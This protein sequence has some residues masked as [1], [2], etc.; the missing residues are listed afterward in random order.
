MKLLHQE[1]NDIRLFI[2][3]KL[4][5]PRHLHNALEVAFMTKGHSTAICG[6]QRIDLQAGDV[7]VAFPNQ[8]HGYENTVDVGGYVM[9]VPV[10]PYLASFHSI[11]EQKVPVSPLLKKG[12]WEH[13]GIFSLLDMAFPEWLTAPKTVRQGYS[14]LIVGKLM[15]LL[16]LKDAPSGCADALQALLLFINN[17]YTE[18]LSRQEIAQAVGYNESY[19]SHIFSDHLN[20]TLTD[21]ITSLRINDAKQLLTDTDLTVSQIA[22]HLGFGC[23]RSFNR[24]FVKETGASP[25]AYRASGR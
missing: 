16:T 19:I 6:N 13:T 11:M 25:T 12:Q 18:P 3:K 10:H 14:Q 20:T 21:Y 15:P 8:E 2:P 17:H 24:A 5:F 7:F 1:N 23:I 4:D 22:A 9:I